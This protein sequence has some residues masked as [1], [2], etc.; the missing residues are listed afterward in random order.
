[1][2]A[3]AL[4]SLNQ[5]KAQDFATI[6]RSIEGSSSLNEIE[7]SL[8]EIN[9]IL[10]DETVQKGLNDTLDAPLLLR[11]LLKFAIENPSLYYETA[12][13]IAMGI[14]SAHAE[15]SHGAPRPAPLDQIFITLQNPD[16]FKPQE[17]SD[18]C[19][20]YLSTILP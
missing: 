2:I 16:A 1:M 5:N 4:R 19:K 9:D 10:T 8:D 14:A 15:I 12:E 6:V 18:A 7:D 17:F 11:A 20:K 13:Q 3:I